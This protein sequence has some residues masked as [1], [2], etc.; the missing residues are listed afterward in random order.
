MNIPI[1]NMI[2]TLFAADSHE[3]CLM[4]GDPVV[5]T[6]D[7]AYLMLKDESKFLMSEWDIKRHNKCKLQMRC[8]TMDDFCGDGCVHC[9]IF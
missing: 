5:R 4:C 3:T 2:T 6:F 1:I 9:V 8:V 7:G